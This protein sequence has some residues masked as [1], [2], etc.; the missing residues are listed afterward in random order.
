[1]K[2]FQN[3]LLYYFI[4]LYIFTYMKIGVYTLQKSGTHIVSDIISLMVDSNTDIYKTR[5]F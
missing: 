3:N 5:D 2:I 4:I 1:M